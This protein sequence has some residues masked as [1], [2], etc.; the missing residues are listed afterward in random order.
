[1][2]W[3]TKGVDTGRV[4]KIIDIPSAVA[5]QPNNSN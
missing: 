3:A 1:M 2:Q 5:F 4:L